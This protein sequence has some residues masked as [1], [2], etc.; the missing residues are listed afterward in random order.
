ME[1]SRRCAVT[2]N[3]FQ[4]STTSSNFQFPGNKELSRVS[5]RIIQSGSDRD[6]RSQVVIE[7]V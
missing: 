1:V 6:P 5:T 4:V 7:N 3:C 2:P